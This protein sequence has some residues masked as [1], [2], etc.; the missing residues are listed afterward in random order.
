MGQARKKV[1]LLSLWCN[2]GAKREKEN[3]NGLNINLL[4]FLVAPQ[5]G[6][7]ISNTWKCKSTAKIRYFGDSN[8]TGCNA[9]KKGG[10]KL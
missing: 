6:L 1:V 4:R 3:R 10:A 8:K 9:V 2:R 7:N 5:V